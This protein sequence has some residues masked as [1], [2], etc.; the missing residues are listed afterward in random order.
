MTRDQQLESTG[1]L[2]AVGFFLMVGATSVFVLLGSSVRST[3]GALRSTRLQWEER[4]IELDKAVAEAH[5][6]GKLRRE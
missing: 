4:T 2:A 1:T 5:A 3:A 6:A